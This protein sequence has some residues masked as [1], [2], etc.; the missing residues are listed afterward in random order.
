MDLQRWKRDIEEEMEEARMLFHTEYQAAMAKYRV[1]HE[2]WTKHEAK[3]VQV[4]T[5]LL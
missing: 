2:Q 3:M 5:L 4:V 1:E